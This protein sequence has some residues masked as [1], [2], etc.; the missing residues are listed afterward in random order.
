MNR[1]KKSEDEQ[2]YTVTGWTV[3]KSQLM[4]GQRGGTSVVEKRVHSHRVDRD[5]ISADEQGYTVTGWT[6]MKS[7][8]MN[9][10]VQSPGRPS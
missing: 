4:N 10:G 3:V 9:R 6:V 1:G 5:E 2:G 7:Q 8:Q